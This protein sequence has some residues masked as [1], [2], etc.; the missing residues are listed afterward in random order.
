[1]A[2]HGLFGAGVAAAHDA[3]SCGHTDVRPVKSMSN[4]VVSVL[5]SGIVPLLSGS[6]FLINDGRYEGKH[7]PKATSSFGEPLM[8]IRLRNSAHSRLRSFARKPSHV[9]LSAVTLRSASP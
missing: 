6:N 8:R 5:S 9:S 2:G 1:M 3:A 7:L 4:F